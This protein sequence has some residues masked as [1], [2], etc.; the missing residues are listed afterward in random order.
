MGFLPGKNRYL[1][2]STSHVLCGNEKTRYVAIIL[3]LTLLR[4][5]YIA[6]DSNAKN[7]SAELKSSADT[8]EEV[9]NSSKD[10][11]KAELEKLRSKAESA[12]KTPA[13]A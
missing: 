13:R 8:L 11:P 12:C 5:N 7:L 2:L 4:N 10:K 3:I 1:V 9:L 6:H